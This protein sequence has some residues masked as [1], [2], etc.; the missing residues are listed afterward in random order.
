ML[1]Q[2]IASSLLVL[3]TVEKTK[4]ES[5]L[6]I[7]LP[8][9]VWFW[10]RLIR[11]CV[12]SPSLRPLLRYAFLREVKVWLCSEHGGSCSS[13]SVDTR[14]RPAAKE[15]CR[16]ELPFHWV[17][18]HFSFHYFTTGNGL[19]WIEPWVWSQYLSQFP[20]LSRALC[21]SMIM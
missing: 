19:C 21:S 14:R 18:L 13:C 17:W 9:S 12:L 5:L 1:D 3:F 16:G 8:T 6:M 20:V 10:F 7:L 4:F 15:C 2:V 11:F